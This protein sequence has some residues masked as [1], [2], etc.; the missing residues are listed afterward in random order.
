M[1]RDRQSPAPG[2]SS[3]VGE[4]RQGERLERDEV[5]PLVPRIV[6]IHVV[7]VL[8]T[9][10]AAQM[11]EASILSRGPPKALMPFLSIQGGNANPSW[12]RCWGSGGHGQ[13]AR[14]GQQACTADPEHRE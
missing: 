13:A 9:E 2:R 5:S 6:V 7:V 11:D 14:A 12:L 4:R 8:L 3:E 10:C 1:G